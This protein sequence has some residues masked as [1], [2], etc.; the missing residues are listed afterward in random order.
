MPMAQ[1]RSKEKLQQDLRD[2]LNE[3]EELRKKMHNGPLTDSESK[4]IKVVTQQVKID[5]AENRRRFGSIPPAAGDGVI[6]R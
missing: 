3:L 4:R 5:D 1:Q 6:M 2:G